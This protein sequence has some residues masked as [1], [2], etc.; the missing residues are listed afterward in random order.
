MGCGQAKAGGLTAR[1]VNRLPT[2]TPIPPAVRLVGL[3][4]WLGMK[5][6]GLPYP[7]RLWRKWVRGDRATY[8]GCGC[9]VWLKR[10]TT[11]GGIKARS[12]VGAVPVDTG[13]REPMHPAHVYR[14]RPKPAQAAEGGAK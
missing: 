6:F 2:N 4:E 14:P 1:S 10:L 3:Y 9:I 5:W 8:P 13:H 12:L 11:W 7:V